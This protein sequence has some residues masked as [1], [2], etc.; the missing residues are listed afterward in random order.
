[1]SILD[2]LNEIFDEAK[3]ME[4]GEFTDIPAGTYK[5]ILKEVTYN[6]KNKNGDPYCQAMFVIDGGEFDLKTHSQYFGLLHSKPNVTKIWLSKFSNFAKSLG[7]DV[8]NGL[9]STVEQL[10][11]LK[12]VE[13]VFEITRDAKDF[14]SVKITELS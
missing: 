13:C 2:E 12:A 6:E 3:D 7:V 11:N 10:T 9:T 8:S 1:M 14:T 5:G 4:G